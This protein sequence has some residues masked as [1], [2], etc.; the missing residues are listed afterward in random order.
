[1]YVVMQQICKREL[2]AT[3]SRRTELVVMQ[4]GHGVSGR[5]L[6]HH[7]DH[8][9]TAPPKPCDAGCYITILT[10]TRRITTNSVRLLKLILKLISCGMQAYT[11]SI[12][13]VEQVH[14][15]HGDA[16]G[17]PWGE[18]ALAT[19]SQGMCLEGHTPH[20]GVASA[21]SLQKPPAA[22]P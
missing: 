5:S 2:Q 22:S 6:H 1:M 4:R 20:K 14:K 3:Q 10:V 13:Q 12:N 17:G 9:S 21:H 15:A 18:W 8:A 19:P 16:A 11:V 7:M